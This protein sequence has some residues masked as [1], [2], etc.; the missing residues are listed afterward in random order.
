[1]ATHPQ[2]EPGTPRHPI[3]V[4]A[5]RTGLTPD[6]LRAWE[7][8]YRAVTPSRA[9]GG[10]RLYSDL[11]VE[12]LLLLRRATGAGRRIGQVATLT[13]DALRDLVRQD[14]Q[15]I[16]DAPANRARARPA[17][18]PADM[19]LEE[20]YRA[21]KLLR[22]DALE[23]ALD[24]ARV[25]LSLPVLI[26]QVVSP[27]LERIGEGWKTGSLRIAG[28]HMASAI[29]RSLLGVLMRSGT[30]SAGQPTMVVA[31]PAG[32]VHELGALMASLT[33]AEDGWRVSYLGP[34]LPAEDIAAAAREAGARCLALSI[35]FPADDPKL[36]D[37][38]RR[39]RRVLEDDV[40]ILVGGRASS[41]YHEVFQEIG[42][43]RLSALGD[44]RDELQLLRVHA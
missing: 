5:R 26:E 43:R 7:K 32:Q 42:A 44:L 41:R 1:M 29:V 23:T 34:N 2:S 3:Q 21:V 14:E 18:S 12:R 40:Q 20:C 25:E 30:R 9:A 36:P 16:A 38:L 33:A 35:V 19:H 22:A 37:E 27:L 11:D 24:D 15:A 8:R 13:T 28:E 4:V 6:A 10:R 39:L 31:T 17:G